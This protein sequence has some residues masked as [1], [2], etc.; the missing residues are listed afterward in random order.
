MNFFNRYY[1]KTVKLS[2]LKYVTQENIDSA[3][4]NVTSADMYAEVHELN[5]HFREMQRKRHFFLG[6]LWG[7]VS[8]L[9]ATLGCA[10]LNFFIYTPQKVEACKLM[11]SILL[12][13][14]K[15]IWLCMA[16]AIVLALMTVYLIYIRKIFS[17]I[18]ALVLMLILSAVH[19]VFLIPTFFLPII[20]NIMK[21]LDDSIKDDVG[22]PHFVMLT[23][24]YIRD[25]ENAEDGVMDEPECKIS[26]DD[27]RIKPEDDEGFL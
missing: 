11:P 6:E 7:T 9:S 15:N 17:W 22:Y 10:M 19:I 1:N 13:T 26:F 12:Y 27:Y 4:V 25:E 21:K 23:A 16:S 18:L 8:L 3:T 2:D 5:D 20:I 24:S 14:S